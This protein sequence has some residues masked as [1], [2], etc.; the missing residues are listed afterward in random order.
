MK[1]AKSMKNVSPAEPPLK[2]ECDSEDVQL[3]RAILFGSEL[4][5]VR[6]RGEWTVFCVSKQ[7]NWRWPVQVTNTRRWHC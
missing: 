3:S 7:T 2:I 4:I 5:L 6:V 1:R